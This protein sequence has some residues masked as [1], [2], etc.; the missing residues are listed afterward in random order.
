[1]N[2]ALTAEVLRAKQLLQA[3]NLRAHLR[4]F[5]RLLNGFVEIFLR[6]SCAGHLNQPD[7]KFI[8]GHQDY[9]TLVAQPAIIA[10]CRCV[11]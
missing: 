4:C 10:D 5:A 11:L 2:L 3:H 7:A 6:V 1:M 9:S 8:R